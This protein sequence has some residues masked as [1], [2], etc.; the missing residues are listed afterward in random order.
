MAL[1]STI[2][3]LTRAPNPILTLAPIETFGPIL[4]ESSISA[5]SWMKHGSTISGPLRALLV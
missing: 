4:A 3:S 1:S 5:L 2:A